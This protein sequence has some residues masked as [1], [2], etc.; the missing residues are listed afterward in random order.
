MDTKLRAWWSHRQGLDGSLVGKTAREAL[1]HSGWSRSV[2]GASPYLTLLGRTGLRRAEIDADLAKQQIHELPSARGCTYV[3]PAEDYALAL[4]V[5]QNFSTKTEIATAKKLGVTDAEVSKLKAAVLK[6]LASDPL[7]TDAIKTAVGP[8]ARSLGPEGVK[9]G[10][11]TTLP[12]ALGILQSEGEIRRIPVNGRIDQQRYKYTL[13]KQNPLAKWKLDTD[14]SFTEL[15][16]R[17]YKWI[18]VASIAEFQWFSGLGVKAA[19][20]ATDPL[21]LVSVQGDLMATQEDAEAF[22]KF[23]VPKKPRYLSP[24][25]HSHKNNRWWCRS[26]W[27]CQCGADCW[28]PPSRWRWR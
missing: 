13:W 22:A 10:L 24:C 17:Y 9:K 4:K 15:A 8:D 25:R 16:R 7:D 23:Q 20:A 5:G 3:V 14:A 27:C 12:L 19:K 28:W 26:H 21:K 6:A 2:G 18:G 1:N 11:A